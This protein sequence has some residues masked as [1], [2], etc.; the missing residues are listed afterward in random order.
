MDS[1]VTAVDS[2]VKSAKVT[3]TIFLGMTGKNLLYA[4]L[5][6]QNVQSLDDFPEK[7]SLLFDH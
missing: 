1:T 6:N 7:A 5:V 3:F 4:L 2:L